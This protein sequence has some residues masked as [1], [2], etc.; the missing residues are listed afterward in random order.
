MK[1]EPKNKPGIIDRS[2]SRQFYALLAETDLS[3][4]VPVLD[5]GG[6]NFISVYRC[7]PRSPALMSKAQALRI[8]W[9]PL[10][11]GKVIRFY[12]PGSSTLVFE[13][14]TAESLKDYLKPLPPCRS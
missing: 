8:L 10:R 7:S 5:I 3:E 11:W 2:H 9:N 12:C 6:G 1:T 13:A 4:A 14:D